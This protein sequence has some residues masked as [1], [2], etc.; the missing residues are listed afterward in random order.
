MALLNFWNYL[1]NGALLLSSLTFAML[2]LS[3]HSYWLMRLRFAV[4]LPITIPLILL[5]PIFAIEIA[6][7]SLVK[8]EFYW[9]IIWKIILWISVFT[10]SGVSFLEMTL[11]S[12]EVTTSAGFENQKY[13][14]IKF[15]S[16]DSLVVQKTFLRHF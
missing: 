1:R 5:A 10:L 9:R 14:L 3:G 16:I 6:L 7:S 13:Y 15:L 4:T 2:L 12:Y 11:R 8:K